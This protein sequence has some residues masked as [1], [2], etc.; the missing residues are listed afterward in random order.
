[1]LLGKF[2]GRNVHFYQIDGCEFY[3]IRDK[4][5]GAA[6]CRDEK[7]TAVAVLVPPGIS[8]KQGAMRATAALKKGEFVHVEHPL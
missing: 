3:V 8:L 4:Q 5:F 2:K 7:S 6:L 1:M